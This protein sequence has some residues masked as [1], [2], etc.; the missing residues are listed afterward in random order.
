MPPTNVKYSVSWSDF[1][2]IPAR[3][4]N[5]KEDAKI[6]IHYPYSYDNSRDKNSAKA[7]SVTMNIEAV[8]NACGVVSA[9]TTDE[10][11]KHEQGHYDIT[12]IGARELYDKISGLSAKTEDDLDRK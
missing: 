8:T 2:H 7:T 11:L 3:P 6:K 4:A 12:A 10:L 9:D 1:N 5:A